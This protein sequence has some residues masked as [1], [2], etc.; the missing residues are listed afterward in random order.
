MSNISQLGASLQPLELPVNRIRYNQENLG[1][2]FNGYFFIVEVTVM[3]ECR[4]L[5]GSAVRSVVL[6]IRLTN[7]TVL[8]RDKIA[9][10]VL[11]SEKVKKAI[12][13]AFRKQAGALTKASLT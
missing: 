3:G 6:G 1:I 11:K 7:A 5:K 9:E 8:N 2:L 10:E 13:E 4:D 12:H